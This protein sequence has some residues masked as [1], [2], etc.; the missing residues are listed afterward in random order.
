MTVSPILARRP[1]LLAAL[2]ALPGIAIGAPASAED[3]ERRDYLPSDI[4]VSADRDTYAEQDGSSATHTPTAIIDVPQGVTVITGD[5]IE[6][7]GITSLNAAL[8][9]VPGVSLESGE[10]H[11]DEVFIRGQETTADFYLDG[12]RDDAQYY[13]PLY[14]IDRVEVLKGANA[15]IFGRGAGGGAVNRVAKRAN[16]S[17]PFAA[18]SASVDT[19]GAFDIAGDVNLAASDVLGVR[20]NATYEEFDNHRDFYEGRF[21]GVSPTLTFAPGPDTRVILSYT[22]DNDERVTDRG[23]PA[24]NGLPLA[25]YDETFFGDP[26]YNW[27]SVEAHV[28]RA[29]IEHDFSPVL[30][31]NAN[32]QYANYDKFYANLVPGSGTTATTV[33]LS[34]YESA[35]KRENLIGQANLIANFATGPATHTLLV[36]AEFTNADTDST[37]DRALFNGGTDTSVTVDLEDVIDPPAFILEPQRATSSELSTLSFYVQEQLEIGIFQ[38]IAGI[39]YDEFDLS[40]VDLVA[41]FAAS[42]KDSSWSPRVGAI[43]KPMDDLSVY[44]SWSKSFLPQSGDQFTSLSETTVALDPE[45]F[46]NLEAGVKW[47]PHPDLLVTGAIFR[48]TRNNTQ[49][50][51]PVNPG[52]V[53]LAGESRVQ[54]FELG[55][56]GNLAENLNV[57]LGYAN[58]DGEV[59]ATTNSAAQGTVL[60][61]VPRHH[62]TAWARYDFN[63]L[64][65]GGLGLVHR[66]DQ[67]ASMSNNVVLPAHT[68]VDAAIYA[69]LSENISVQLNIENLLDETYYASAHGDNNIQ[70]GVPFNASLGARVR[71]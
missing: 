34:G 30:S 11:R 28:A 13:R 3:Q 23:V 8:A 36:G 2:A 61:Q 22:Y 50:P 14:N 59:T 45:T 38:L 29:R 18:A 26:D 68:R 64:L 51:D 69:A 62:V 32:L 1:V 55:L 49:A 20:I 40:S 52:F 71:F 6:D 65:G 10:G 46:E 33:N 48:L 35:T 19:F 57:S 4:I 56:A 12:L 5:Q 66:S 17:R 54:G 25:G 16:P 15:L 70:P 24:F 60:Q 37:R 31:A 41:S 27:G 44:T 9:F 43:V 53:I 7:Q 39:R 21:I 58:L 42:R 63:E 47:S 67:F